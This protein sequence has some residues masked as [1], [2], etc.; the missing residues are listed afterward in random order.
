MMHKKRGLRMWIVSMLAASPK[1][2]VEMM[3]EV[4]AMTHG[5]W[6]PS[7]GSVYP[8]LDELTKEGLVRKRDDGR[9]ELTEKASEELD[10]GMGPPF[11]RPQSVDDMLNEVSG[12]VSYLEDLKGTD[13]AKLAAHREKIKD[14]AERLSRLAEKGGKGGA[15]RAK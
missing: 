4:E 13:E 14:M 1:N 15:P 8:L 6:R 10:W 11:R 3:N 9:Y 2:G 5:W 12:F 7:P